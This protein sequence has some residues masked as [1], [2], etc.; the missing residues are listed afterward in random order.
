MTTELIEL[1]SANVQQLTSEGIKGDWVVRKNITGE[2]LHSFKPL[3]DTVMTEVLNFA[4]HYELKAFNIGID[5]QKKKNNAVLEDK[6]RILTAVNKELADENIR[7]AT[8][9][10]NLIPED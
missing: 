1:Q 10:E 6:I 5:F 7:L 9:L 4:R 3:P 2:S 8:L